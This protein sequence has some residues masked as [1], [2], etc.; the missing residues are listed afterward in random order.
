MV[1]RKELNNYCHDYLNVASFED[2]S[3]NGLQIEG[4]E[5]INN[6]VSGVRAK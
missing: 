4:V 6:I 1:N 5:N 3:P 2:Y